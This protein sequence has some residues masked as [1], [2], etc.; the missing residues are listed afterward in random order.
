MECC[1]KC[2][3]CKLENR[4]IYKEWVCTN[5]ESDNYGMETEYREKCE[6][7]EERG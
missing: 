1:G 7:F 2:K 5:K 4:G 3:H 6:E